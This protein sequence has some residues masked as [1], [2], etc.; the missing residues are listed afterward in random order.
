MLINVYDGD[1][2]ELV[3]ERI[4]LLEALPEDDERAEA[5]AEL[6]KSGRVWIGGGAEALFLLTLVR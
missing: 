3:A 6:Q 5:R 4:P 1:T 2:Q